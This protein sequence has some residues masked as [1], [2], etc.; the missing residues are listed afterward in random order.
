MSLGV[1]VVEAGDRS[2]ASISA[3]LAAEQ[4]RDVFAVPG[5]IDSRM[6]RGCHKLIRDGATLVETVGDV[7]D[8]LGPLVEPLKLGDAEAVGEQAKTVHHPAELKLSDQERNVLNCIET[9]PTE[10]DVIVEKTRL[11]PARILATVSVLGYLRRV[12][13]RFSGQ[14]CSG[15]H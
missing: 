12:L 10:F 15:S 5:R 4:G 6:S 8:H 11:P 1:I 7:L 14:F 13:G 3:R 9:V 2:G